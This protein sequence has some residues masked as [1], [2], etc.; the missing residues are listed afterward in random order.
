MNGTW[1]E[2]KMK[3]H[4]YN[5]NNTNEKRKE[6]KILYRITCCTNIIFIHRNSSAYVFAFYFFFSWF[7]SRKS[8]KPNEELKWK[9]YLNVK[10][11]NEKKTTTLVVGYSLSLCLI[12]FFFVDT[13]VA[14]VVVWLMLLMLCQFNLHW[15]LSDKNTKKQYTCSE[16]KW[17]SNSN[18]FWLV[19]VCMSNEIKCSYV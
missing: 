16:T 2:R 14:V 8:I 18:A 3:I 7:Q 4:N 9:L 6:I 5:N 1:I 19:C 15:K 11:P 10:F 13:M 12:F 17:I